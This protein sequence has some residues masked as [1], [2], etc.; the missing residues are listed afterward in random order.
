VIPFSGRPESFGECFAPGIHSPIVK[1]VVRVPARRIVRRVNLS[2][3]TTMPSRLRQEVEALPRELAFEIAGKAGTSVP[4]IAAA[5]R[6]HG[7]SFCQ[8]A[9]LVRELAGFERSVA[10]FRRAEQALLSQPEWV[11]VRLRLAR[12]NDAIWGALD[13][14][15]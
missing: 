1:I 4:A 7:L 9:F 8:A 15:G 11:D 10:G 5:S 12:R 2:P 3:D 13:L 6:L 14:E